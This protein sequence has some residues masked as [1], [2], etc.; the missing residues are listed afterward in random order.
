MNVLLSIKPT[1]VK[2]IIAGN[3]KYEFR[4]V[5]F[6]TPHKIEKVFIYSSY[7]VKNIIGTFTIG[8]IIKGTPEDLWHQ[9]HQFAG[10]K[11][12]D[13]FKYFNNKNQG[14]A[15]SIENIEIFLKPLDPYKSIIDFKAP[16][17]FC[18][19]ENNFIELLSK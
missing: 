13:F 5:I 6:K 7:P 16:Q 17:S 9:C 11:K 1:Y 15:I 18:Y 19:V 12:K 3:K 10:I 2:E 14:F 4:K 8:K